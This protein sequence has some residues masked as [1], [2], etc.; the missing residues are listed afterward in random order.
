MSSAHTVW[1]E[2]SVN[3]EKRAKKQGHRSCIVWFTG[4]SGSG[5]STIAHAVE[6][7]LFEQNIRT[8]VM[9]GDNIR[10]GLNKDLSFTPEDR[11]ENIRR[12][13]ELT[14]L[15]VDAGIIIFTAFI[16]PYKKDR[17]AVRQL[18][19]KGEFIEVHVKCSLE[20]CER[21]DPKGW[22]RKA[23]AGEIKNYTGVSS[24]YEVPEKPDLVLETDKYSVNECVDRV[25]TYLKEADIVRF[26]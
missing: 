20:E 7:K 16:S 14:K 11:Q 6:E 15:F 4:L 26:E 5:K 10:H 3:K 9:D 1:H 23:K 21:R 24:P 22:Y 8:Y 2:P 13:G 17:D 12:I 25:I 19:P 18:F